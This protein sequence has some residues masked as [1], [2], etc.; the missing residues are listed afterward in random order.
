MQFKQSN[1]Q[2]LLLFNIANIDQTTVNQMT[3][4]TEKNTH[5][6]ISVNMRWGNLCIYLFMLKLL[7]IMIS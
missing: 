7:K 6:F 5:L 1:I 2:Q 4:E 3:T